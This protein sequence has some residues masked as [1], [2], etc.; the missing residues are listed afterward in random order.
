MGHHHE[1]EGAG[2][3]FFSLDLQ[4]LSVLNHFGGIEPHIFPILSKRQPEETERNKAQHR[5]MFIGLAA[6]KEDLTQAKDGKEPYSGAKM[7]EFMDGFGEVLVQHLHEEVSTL[8][9][10]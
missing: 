4:K 3:S 8:F 2:F 5:E 10:I 1:T 9:Q 7:R 6:W